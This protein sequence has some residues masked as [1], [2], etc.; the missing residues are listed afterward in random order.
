MNQI[1]AFTNHAQRLLIRDY[2][3]LTEK[4]RTKIIA[5]YIKAVT[6]EINSKLCQFMLDNDHYIVSTYTINQHSRSTINGKQVCMHKWFTDN[7]PLMQIVNL[8][9]N[10]KKQYTEIKMTYHLEIMIDAIYAELLTKSD[11]TDDERNEYAAQLYTPEFYSIIGNDTNE[12]AYTP[13]DVDSLHAYIIYISNQITQVQYASKGINTLKRRLKEAK[14]IYSI[15]RVFNGQLP[16]II[17]NSE[18]GRKYYR[19]PNLQSVSKSVRHA[20]LGRCI[21]YDIE[22]SVYAWRYTETMRIST[23]AGVEIALPATLTY[24][25][26]KSAIREEIALHTFEDSQHSTESAV[27]IIKEAFTAIGFGAQGSTKTAVWYINGEKKTQ[28]LNAIIY[29]PK[30]RK[31]FLEHP[32]VLQ[33]IE[34]QKVISSIIFEFHSKDAK[35][36]KMKCL[37][38]EAGK[39]SKPKTLA[40]F[41]QQ[42][43]RVLLDTAVQQLDAGNILLTVHDAF[44]IKNA[45]AEGIKAAKHELKQYNKELDL[46]KVTHTANQVTM[47]PQADIDKASHLHRIT[48]EK[49]NAKEYIPD[50]PLVKLRIKTDKIVSVESML[51]EHG[52]QAADTTYITQIKDQIRKDESIN[53]TRADITKILKERKSQRQ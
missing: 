21:E 47:Q 41:Y 20:A 49:R 38:T 33:F 31:L 35:L 34:E 51:Y 9:S 44:Y 39:L 10:I 30:H 23:D 26:R 8:G 42:Q 13:I 15:A 5:R 48:Q 25:E 27:K 22:N 32:F 46:G 16:L 28:S 11:L 36:T 53:T 7:C 18:F 29:S 3:E 24:L 40:Y 14:R 6:T 1:T 37:Q 43:E 50:S 2:P 12:V 52:K 19:G 17:N 4:H 45:D